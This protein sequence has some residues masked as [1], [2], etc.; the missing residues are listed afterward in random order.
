M[1]Y[2]SS[3][4][5]EMHIQAV[6]RRIIPNRLAKPMWSTVLMVAEVK[7]QIEIPVLTIA[8]YVL[9]YVYVP[10][11]GTEDSWRT[12]TYRTEWAMAS[13]ATLNHQRV[14]LRMTKVPMFHHKCFSALDR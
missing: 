8:S 11:L 13:I 12:E 7:H 9:V 4:I 5:G 6:N 10:T 2:K 1:G 3:T 14:V